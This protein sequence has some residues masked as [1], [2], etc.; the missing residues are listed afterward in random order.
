MEFLTFFC[1]NGGG[2]P[3]LQTLYIKKTKALTGNIIIAWID[4]EVIAFYVII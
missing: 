4:Y 3:C 2:K 1:L